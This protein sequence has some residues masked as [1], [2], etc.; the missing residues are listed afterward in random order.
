[1]VLHVRYVVRV[2]HCNKHTAIS[3]SVVGLDAW[4][5]GN[6]RHVTLDYFGLHSGEEQITKK[7]EFWMKNK[8][9]A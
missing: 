4:I 5:V 8:Y 9:C 2:L 6:P 3:S 1:M 7:F